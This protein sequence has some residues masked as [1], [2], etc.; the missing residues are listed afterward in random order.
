VSTCAGVDVVQILRGLGEIR[1]RTGERQGGIGLTPCGNGYAIR[2]GL[3]KRKE[4][5]IALKIAK[6][7]VGDPGCNIA[8]VKGLGCN[9]T[10][11]ENPTASYAPLSTTT[12]TSAST[13]E[14]TVGRPASTAG[15]PGGGFANR[16]EPQPG[17]TRWSGFAIDPARQRT[18]QLIEPILELNEYT[19]PTR[20]GQSETVSLLLQGEK[21]VCGLEPTENEKCALLVKVCN[22]YPHTRVPARFAGESHSVTADDVRAMFPMLNRRSTPG[23]PW[24][25]LAPTKGQLLDEHGPLVVEAVLKRLS[26]LQEYADKMP[27]DPQELVELGLCDPVRVFVKD[28]PHTKVKAMEGRWRLISSVSIVDEIIERLLCHVQNETEIDSWLKCPSK[29]GI[30]LSQ[31]AQAQALWQEVLPHLATAAEAD[32]SGWDWSVPWWLLDL[33]VRA[34]ILLCGA[35]PRSSFARILHA[36]MWCL[37]RS[38]FSTTD[39]QLFKQ[40]VPGL[41]KSGSYLTSSTNSRMRVMLAWLIGADWAIAMGDDSLEQETPGAAER[42]ALYGFR[43]KMYRRCGQS[44][45]FCSH[46]FTDGVAVPLNW[47]KGLYRLLS[48]TPNEG[49]VVQF[50]EEYRHSPFLSTCLEVISRVW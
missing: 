12:A 34:R 14:G 43:V 24:A 18:R 25:A 49:L 47:A 36:R 27:S 6:G 28:E 37:A 46:R 48:A 41:M 17:A 7:G 8:G 9:I 22:E 33:D 50:R 11:A 21:H 10:E 20:G 45:E 29:P 31:D 2:R 1:W 4:E 35:S 26:L 40:A 38:V 5:T 23:L 39:G 3:P 15:A 19:W 44:F 42:Y 16:D 13:T 30:G 32:V